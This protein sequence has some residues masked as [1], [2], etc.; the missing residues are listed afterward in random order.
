MVLLPWAKVR[1]VVRSTEGV[2]AQYQ[3]VEKV[4]VPLTE[5]KAGYQWVLFGL[6]TDERGAFQVDWLPP[7]KFTLLGK[8]YE[9]RPGQV[10]NL[11]L[12]VE[13]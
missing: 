12:T 8:T 3:T 9:V 7:G 2:P 1:A 10:L 13:P 6:K 4:S 5:A 11:D